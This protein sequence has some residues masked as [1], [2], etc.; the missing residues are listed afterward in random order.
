MGVGDVVDNRSAPDAPAIRF[1]DEYTTDELLQLLTVGARI[2]LEEV[3]RHP[4]GACYPDPPTVVRPK[5]PGWQGRLDVGSAEMLRDLEEI[6]L[7][8]DTRGDNDEIF[9]F[10]MIC[11]RHAHVFNSSCNLSSTNHGRGYNPAFI[12][13]ADL[14][15]LGLVAGDHVEI[16]S[17]R[18]VIPAIVEPDDTLRRGLVSMMFGFGGGPDRDQDVALIGSSPSRLLDT[19]AMFDRYTGQPRMSNVPVRLQKV[20]ER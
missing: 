19:D 20:E 12:H 9:D 7:T 5:E 8:V 1:T 2:P 4:G 3:K 17:A 13:P 15:E 18:S 14:Y 10:R 11:R 6:A 16:H